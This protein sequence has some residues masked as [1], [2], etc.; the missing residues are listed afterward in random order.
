[1]NVTSCYSVVAMTFSETCGG[2]ADDFTPSR[3]RKSDIVLADQ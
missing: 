1:M 2:M 3:Q